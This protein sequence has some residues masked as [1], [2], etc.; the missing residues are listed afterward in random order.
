[1][2][3]KIIF[4]FCT[5]ISLFT[6]HAQTINILD[7]SRKVSL[8][9]LSVVDDNVF[10]ASGSS[11][12]VVRSTDGGQTLEWLT[13]KGYEQRDFRDIEAMNANFAYIMAVDKPGLILRTMDGGKNWNKV[14]EDTA[15]G[16]FLDAMAFNKNGVTVAVGDPLSDMK[17]YVIY[18][19]NK[20]AEFFRLQK[21]QMFAQGEAFFASSGTNVQFIPGT[22]EFVTVS[23]GRISRFHHLKMNIILPL[24]QGTEST[25]ANSISV[26][27]NENMYVV[28]GDFSNDKDATG[29]ACFTTDGGKTW[30][31]PTQG[32]HG[33]RSCV[34]Y[35]SKNKLIS[36]G[37]NG[38]DISEDGGL[39]WKNIST[40][41]FHVCQVSK[42]G[43]SIFLA[44]PRG[45][46]AKLN[47][48]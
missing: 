12:T 6:V 8:R 32:P 28:G 38:V 15:T 24:K 14:Y 27:D 21:E 4:L 13:V 46:I 41:G 9:G 43:N 31:L 17:A 11:G 18:R 1:M 29:N 30:Q 44:G 16:V 48:E 34:M 33:Y 42:N 7:S 47:F 5:V 20:D 36:C 10:W 45:R 35:I 3:K 23:G 26:W 40:L 22:D 39:T 2:N 19:K 37:T 25:G